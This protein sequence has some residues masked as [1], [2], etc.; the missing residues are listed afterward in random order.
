MGVESLK[1]QLEERKSIHA[2]C[3]G[4]R[5]FPQAYPKEKE[6]SEQCKRNTITELLPVVDN[7]ERARSLKPQTDAELS[8]H[9]ATKVFTNNW[10]TASS[11][12]EYQQ[13]DLRGNEFDPICTKP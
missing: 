7:F 8:I 3:S 12:W 2:D 13:C 9:K 4:F 6:D 5:K 10:L 1:A 11:A